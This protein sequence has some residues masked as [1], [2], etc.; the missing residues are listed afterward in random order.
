[1]GSFV[2]AASPIAGHA[3]PIIRVAG[4]LVARGHRVVV[5][6][7]SRFAVAA[8]RSGAE[9]EPLTG[10]ADFDDRDQDS[11]I[12]RRHE[13]SGVRRAQYEIRSIFVDTIPDQA[14]ALRRAVEK[15][16]PDAVL[17]D[18][19][20]AGALLLLD[21]RDGSR[22]E[23]P[24]ILALGVTPLSYASPGLAPYGMGMAPATN[25]VERV[26]Y[27]LLDV[28][29]RRI[30][31]RPT[32]QAGV[33]AVHQA[34]G[35]LVGSVMDLATRFDAF[36]QTGPEGLEYPRSDLPSTVRFVGTL[37]QPPSA[38][39]MPT[40]WRDLDGAR[41]V[42]HVTQGTI[43]NADPSRVILPAL[44]ALASRDV[45]VIA[46]GGGRDVAGWGPLPDNARAAPYLPYGELLPRTDLLITN[47]GYGAVQSAVAHGIPVIVAGDTEEKP[48]VAARVA[49]SRVGLDLKTGRPSADAIGRAVDT[50]L[51]DPSFRARARQLS[52]QAGARRPFDTIEQA[53]LSTR[54]R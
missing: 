25:A 42:V 45:L 44:E 9:F 3:G 43:D 49:W 6:T 29:A 19:A 39:P 46:T 35:S 23:R 50:V 48:E 32:Q 38:D 16:R 14:R 34:G 24:P 1:M 13:F 21:P 15:H 31:F 10:V 26:K 33:A 28:A 5:V 17:V 7:G 47:G 52:E 18:G 53:L 11:Y 51:A 8:L 41:P 40:W 37:P 27:R 54:P 20:F 36:L 30:V 12:P 4:D 2:L 22:G